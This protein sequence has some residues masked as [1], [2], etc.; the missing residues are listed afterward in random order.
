MISKATVVFGGTANEH[1]ISILTGLQAERVLSGAGVT[2][3][4]LAV[5]QR[6]LGDPDIRH[7]HERYVNRPGQTSRQH[8]QASD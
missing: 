8:R 2:V 4:S 1:D 6:S 7:G 3:Q 5:G